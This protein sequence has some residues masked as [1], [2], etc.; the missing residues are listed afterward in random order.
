MIACHDMVE[1]VSGDIIN[2]EL[3]P[4]EQKKMKTEK[5]LKSI[6]YL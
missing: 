2:H 4:I 6:K 5:E 1:C 3:L